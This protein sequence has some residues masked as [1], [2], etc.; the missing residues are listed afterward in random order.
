MSEAVKC[1]GG[2]GTFKNFQEWT[3]KASSCSECML[4]SERRSGSLSSSLVKTA[5]SLGWYLVMRPRRALISISCRASTEFTFSMPE[6]SG[7]G[8]R[9]RT[10]R[11]ENHEAESNSL[12]VK[13]FKCLFYACMKKNM[14]FFVLTLFSFTQDDKLNE[15]ACV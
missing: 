7:R 13:G 4:L 11:S 3:L 15:D 12:D 1:Y 9:G 10:F 14:F 8:R 2:G 5:E 6:R